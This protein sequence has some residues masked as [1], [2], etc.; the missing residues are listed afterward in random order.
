MQLYLRKPMGVKPMY[1]RRT[2][3]L[4]LEL[5]IPPH[6]IYERMLEL[7]DTTRPS[8]QKKMKTYVANKRRLNADAQL[9]RFL[10]GFFYP[11]KFYDGVEVNE[12]FESDFRPIPRCP[13]LI[14]IDMILILD[15]YFRLTPITM[16]KSTPE[17]Q[18]LAKVIGNTAERIVEVME[19]YKIVDPYLNRNEEFVVSPL[20]APCQK[21][22]QRYGN[23]DIEELA[24]LARQLKEYYSKHW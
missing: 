8:L 11:D 9:V 20:L 23:G 14:P 6:Y 4:S 13:D 16:V 15:L 1:G 22:W 12:T 18:E 10:S 2:V 24:A 21:I 3:N 19:V 17:I 5:H 7:R